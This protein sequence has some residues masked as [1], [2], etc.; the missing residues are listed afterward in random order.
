MTIEITRP[1]IELLIQ[2][3]EQQKGVAKCHDG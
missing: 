2:L 1:K 3:A